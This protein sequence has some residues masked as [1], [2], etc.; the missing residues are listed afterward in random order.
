VADTLDELHAKMPEELIVH[1]REAFHLPE[2]I[3]T[4][5]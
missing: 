4:W 1:P 2:I 3:K 5:E